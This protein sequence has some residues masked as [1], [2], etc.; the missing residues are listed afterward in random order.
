MKKITLFMFDGCPYC[1]KAFEIC[2]EL[3]AENPEY[4]KVEI[5]VVD[6]RKNPAYADKFDYYYVP[7]FYVGNEKVLEGDPSREQVEAAYRKALGL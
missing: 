1:R 6:E 2:E 3:E 7:T 5:E 4:A